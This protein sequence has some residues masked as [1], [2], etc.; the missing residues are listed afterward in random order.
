MQV[1]ITACCILIASHQ[2]SIW[3]SWLFFHH[4]HRSSDKSNQHALHFPSQTESRL[5][6]FQASIRKQHLGISKHSFDILKL[7]TFL[8]NTA[9]RDIK[10]FWNQHIKEKKR[11]NEIEKK[12]FL[13]HPASCF[14][15]INKKADDLSGV[16]FEP[17]P[18]RVDC[19]LNEAP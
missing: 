1:M 14:H 16:E 17:T 13:R 19:D 12:W 8:Q 18:T 9:D 2:F 6:L 11:L 5:S 7:K 3:F 4:V 15:Y 10:N